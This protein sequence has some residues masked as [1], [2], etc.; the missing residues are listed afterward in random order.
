MDA[1]NIILECRDLSVGYTIRNQQRVVQSHLNMVLK[2]GELT[3]LLGANGMGKST[4]LRTLAGV[5]SPLGGELWVN[6][7]LLSGYSERERS[8]QIGIVLTDRT[9]AGG[10]SVY[11]LVALGRQPYTNFLGHLNREDDAVIRKSL[12]AVGMMHKAGSYVA[13]LSDG[14]RQK[15]M[16]AKALVQECPL[17]LLDE[18]TAFLDVVSRIEIMNLLHRLAAEEK[19]AIL[20]STHDIE[21]ALVLADR[22]WLMPRSGG[23]ESG[24]P[25]DLILSHRMDKLFMHESIHFDLMH[26]IYSPR[27]SGTEVVY[28][29]AH[30]ETL[31]H[32]AQNALN[33]NG[34]LC[35]PAGENINFEDAGKGK[36][37]LLDVQAPDKLWLTSNGTR[38]CYPSFEKLLFF[39]HHIYPKQI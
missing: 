38:I 29:M 33:R 25:E 3:C 37:T 14:E 21:Q 7:K 17:I 24:V 2:R 34:F 13:E 39:F 31:R 27:V 32:W 9:M 26:G 16:I 5:Q 23:L 10:L 6:G 1:Q 4:L 20:L 19:R 15:A 22:L 35:L 36:Y 30:D 8:R 11:D 12:E 28:L 18:P